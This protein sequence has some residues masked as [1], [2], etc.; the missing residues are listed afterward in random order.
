MTSAFASETR[1]EIIARTLRAEAEAA[2]GAVLAESAEDIVPGTVVNAV[3]AV[4]IAVISWV[5]ADDLPEVDRATTEAIQS[6]T[7][8]QIATVAAL[9]E[10]A[11]YRV[12]GRQVV[13]S[14]SR[15]PYY[16][17][18]RTGGHVAVAI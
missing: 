15:S 17:A 11:G 10:R 12:T 18:W 7:L 2:I 1:A 6:A 4:G 16:V 8:E 13:A 3:P 9:M 14:G 5:V